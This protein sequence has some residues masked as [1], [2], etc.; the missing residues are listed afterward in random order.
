MINYTFRGK[1]IE[2]LKKMSNNELMQIVNADFRRVLKRG[3]SKEEQIL[4]KKIEK[5]KKDGKPIR[6]HCREMFILP[7]FVGLTI[8]VH[9]GKEFVPV[10]IKPNMIFHRLGEFALTTKQVRHGSPGIGA[11]R[12]ST[13][14]PIK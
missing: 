13:Y 8:Y 4:L 6:T 9:N 11:T 7:S 12:S 14:V 3:F 1:D 2:E 5:H 10:E